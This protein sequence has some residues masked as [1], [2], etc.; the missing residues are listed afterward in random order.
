MISLAPILLLTLI[1]ILLLGFA[2]GLWILT[3]R[4]RLQK[5]LIGI[6]GLWV[7]MFL[8][9][10]V[11]LVRLYNGVQTPVSGV[12]NFHGIWMGL[13]GLFS[14]ISYPAVALHEQKISLCKTLSWLSPVLLTIVVYIVWHLATGTD[15]NY[16]YLT[17]SELWDNRFTM[18]VI[19]RTLMLVLFITY[20]TLV[21]AN[22]WRLIPVYQKYSD[23]NYADTAHNVGW[24]RL[25]I[26]AIGSICVAYLIVL[27][28]KHPLGEIIYAVTTCAF[29]V[30]LAVNAFSRKLFVQSEHISV[31]WSFRYG[32]RLIERQHD[33][34]LKIDFTLLNTRLNTWMQSEK[35]FVN[36]DFA[37]KD[38]YAVFPELRP[39]VLRE[40]LA[41]EGM[42][43]NSYVSKLRIEEACRLM[44]VE[45]GILCKQI[46]LRVG[47]SSSQILSR[48][49]VA[50]MGQTPLEYHKKKIKKE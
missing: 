36:S 11:N 2:A 38:V 6:I 26:A 7:M 37:A 19:L 46:A 49:F 13:I 17:I 23:D 45:P 10:L 40:L 14:L 42:T 48:A 16:R 44:E 27:I 34:S 31:D 41:D 1:I 25:V 12:M 28:W 4:N 29:F 3:E 32:W 5:T 50:V 15:M 35:P 21:L 22:I 43:F 20:L 9:L 33:N 24:L 47:F 30:L 18:P 39:P 8:G